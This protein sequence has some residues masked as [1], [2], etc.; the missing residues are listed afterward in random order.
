[1]Q[2]ACSFFS[3]TIQTSISNVPLDTTDEEVGT[4]QGKHHVVQAQR[5]TKKLGGKIIA[6]LHFTDLFTMFSFSRFS[7][8]FFLQQRCAGCGLDYYICQIAFFTDHNLSILTGD[9]NTSAAY[10]GFATLIWS[11]VSLP[12]PR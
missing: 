9:G 11:I 1:M 4:E 12:F 10:G 3:E 2:L 6:T 8:F 7:P 5:I